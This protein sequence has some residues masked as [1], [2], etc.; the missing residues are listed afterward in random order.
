MILKISDHLSNIEEF[1]N[2]NFITFQTIIKKFNLKIPLDIS[3]YFT[4]EIVYGLIAL[5]IC[6]QIYL[7]KLKG[8]NYETSS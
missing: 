4:I 3:K 1:T 5:K 8:D 7:N 2:N 6:I